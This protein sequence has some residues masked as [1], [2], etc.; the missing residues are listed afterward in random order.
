MA[1][2][3]ICNSRKGKR[4]CLIADGLIC[5]LCCGNT[6]TEATCSKCVFYQ[7]PKRR[8]EEVPRY[9][10]SE[11]DGNMDL[12]SYGNAIEGAL[13]AY[14]I[15][16]EGKLNDS[17]AIRIIELLIDK[18]HFQDQKMDDDH[19]IIVNGVDFVDKSIKE[20]FKDVEDQE[21]VRVLGV[22]RFV[23][24]RRTRIGREYMTVIHQYVGQRIG[25]GLRV[26]RQGD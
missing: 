17:D 8:Y 5:S 25:S 10:V 3:L 6:R 19:Q 21:V 24:K 2:C 22:I 15:E 12:Q 18:Y 4:Q 23:A 14:D 1:K 7:K 11:M 16:T 13:C 9:S 20:D 26:L